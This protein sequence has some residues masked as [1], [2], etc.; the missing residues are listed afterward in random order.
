MLCPVCGHDKSKV[1]WT[2]KSDETV[3]RRR[4][5]FECLTRWAT[6]EHF[7]KVIPPQPVHT[8]KTRKD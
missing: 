4:E 3:I 5:C 6:E 7:Q 1:Y 8:K 2:G